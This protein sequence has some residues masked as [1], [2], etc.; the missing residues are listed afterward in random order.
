MSQLESQTGRLE[1]EWSKTAEALEPPFPATRSRERWLATH[2]RMAQHRPRRAGRWGRIAVAAAVVLLSLAG[3][4]V[5]LQERGTGGQFGR[6]GAWLETRAQE[7]YPLR[8]PDGSM[9]ILHGES[10]VLVERV[11]PQGARLV[12]ERGTVNA[13]IEH[14]ANTGT[15]RHFSKQTFVIRDGHLQVIL[16]GTSCIGADQNAGFSHGVGHLTDLVGRGQIYAFLD[17]RYGLIVPAI[18]PGQIEHGQ[19]GGE[20]PWIARKPLLTVL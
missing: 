20:R 17:M 3:V 11:G 16:I 15:I 1:R 10:R 19:I 8:F 5:W 12:L 4:R 7:E 18:D 14:R 13:R 2:Q 9:A 6:E